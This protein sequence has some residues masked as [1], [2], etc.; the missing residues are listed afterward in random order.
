MAT[1]VDPTFADNAPFQLDLVSE[2][3]NG[4]AEDFT[5][6]T[7]RLQVKAK[8]A[9]GLPTGSPLLTLTTGDGISG[10]LDQGEIFITFPKASEDGLPVGQY[11]Y[12]VLRLVAGE[13][14]ERLYFGT[15]TVTQG[16]TEAP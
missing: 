9:N 16:V 12:D 10:A 13:V 7:F 5:G 4:Q 2:D 14:V 1:Q 6:S 3:Q 8:D 11:V 15:I